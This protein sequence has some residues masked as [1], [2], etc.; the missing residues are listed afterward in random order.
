MG[1]TLQEFNELSAAER[2]RYREAGQR[3]VRLAGDYAIPIVFAPPPSIG[4]KINSGSG[5]ILQLNSA[6]FVVTA[7]HVLAEYESRLQGGELLN[8]LVGN[9]PPFEP[10]PRVVWEDAQK[11]IV[12]L[13]LLREEISRLKG[14]CIIAPP[15]R[16]PP[17]VP[18]AGPSVLL[19]GYPKYLREF[20]ALKAKIDWPYSAVLPA[21]SVGNGYFFCQ[22]EQEELISF[23]R[24]PLPDPK[25]FL[26][27]LSGG[28]VLLVEK[29]SYP[30]VG[31]DVA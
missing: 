19:A 10:R 16:W 29:I 3:M 14:K 22:I 23:N 28:P 15:H 20:N 1:G 9:V 30:V 26:G 31:I 7:H 6:S 25:T 12:I 24:G 11:D 18:E 8:W 27:G 5:F 13:K 21:K 17:S 2:E 4:G